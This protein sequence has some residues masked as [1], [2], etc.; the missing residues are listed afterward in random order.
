MYPQDNVHGM[1]L[2]PTSGALM[3][4]QASEL[5]SSVS[6]NGALRRSTNGGA[7]WSAIVL[8]FVKGAGNSWNMDANANYGVAGTYGYKDAAGNTD[9]DVWLSTDEGVTWA[10]CFHIEGDGDVSSRNTHIHMARIDPDGGCWVGVG[11]AGA[12]M[13]LWYSPAQPSLVTTSADNFGN[14][15]LIYS[16]AEARPIVCLFYTGSAGE[17]YIYFG[18]DNKTNATITRIRYDLGA[19]YTP[20]AV[21]N[22]TA[23]GMK[24]VTGMIKITDDC[25]V[26]CS[27]ND[28]G[29]GAQNK[30]AVTYDA[31]TTWAVVAE[32]TSGL[33]AQPNAIRTGD[34]NGNAIVSQTQFQEK[35]AIRYRPIK[36]R[37]DV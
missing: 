25:W 32:I 4:S 17:K 1:L 11:D 35:P 30:A 13:G 27:S 3:A 8:N 16:P 33:L 12:H 15:S 22:L 18:E 10:S 5:G 9:R 23:D 24:V 34:I 7:N 14:F 28:G 37:L 20:E 26:I 31:G 19:P 36:L 29:A 21:V 6:V 2:F